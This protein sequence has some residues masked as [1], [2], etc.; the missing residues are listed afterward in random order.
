MNSHFAYA[1]DQLDFVYCHWPFHLIHPD[2]PCWNSIRFWNGNKPFRCQIYHE[3]LEITKRNQK[4][5]TLHKL[6]ETMAFLVV[7]DVFFFFPLVFRLLQRDVDVDV[8]RL[9]FP[10]NIVPLKSQ[11]SFFNSWTRSEKSYSGKS[12]TSSYSRMGL[13]NKIW[14]FV[15]TVQTHL[16]R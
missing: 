9:Q 2:W 3:N 15:G 8:G 4:K 16:I 11:W 10:R 14:F 7:F 12:R 5:R 6:G 1:F 13:T